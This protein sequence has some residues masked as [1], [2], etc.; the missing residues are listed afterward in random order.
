MMHSEHK[1]ET[2]QDNVF[3]YLPRLLSDQVVL[4]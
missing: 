3:V 4:T 1:V 2:K